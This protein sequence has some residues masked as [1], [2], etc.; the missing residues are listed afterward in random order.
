M[1]PET[2]LSCNKQHGMAIFDYTCTSWPAALLTNA[3]YTFRS[4]HKRAITQ[5]IKG[6]KKY[7]RMWQSKLMPVTF[8]YISV[9][10]FLPL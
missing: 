9:Y 6:N 7:A 5:E 1:K 3:P 2:E 10:A 4:A 8:L